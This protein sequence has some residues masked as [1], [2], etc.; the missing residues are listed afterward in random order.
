ML[1][2]VVCGGALS[3]CSVADI[4]DG[5]AS[6]ASNGGA[7]AAANTSSCST[8]T[9][10]LE[11]RDPSALPK[12]ACASGGTARCVSKDGIPASLASQ[13]ATC[14]AAA[15]G[16]CVPDAIVAGNA[17]TTCTSS[18][19]EGRCMSLCLPPVAANAS[20]LDRGQEN[21]CAE[22]E[23]CAPCTSPIDGKPTGVCD[24]A[25]PAAS[26]AT[27]GAPTAGGA[28]GQAGGAPPG[29]C[30]YVGPPLV[31]VTRFPACGAGMRCV[32]ANLVPPAAAA[33]LGK[34]DA[35]LCAPEKFIAAGG[36]YLPKSCASLAKAEGRCMNVAIPAV[37]SEQ[38]IL[39]TDAC[40][41]DERCVP[42]FDP[43]D[44]KATGVCS[45]VSCDAP[46]QPATTFAGCCKG[47]GGAARGKCVPS[48]MVPAA[49]QA[50]FD[51][52]TCAPQ[53]LCAPSEN[54]DPSYKPPACT[55]SSFVIGAYAG[56]C[57]SDCLDFGVYDLALETGSCGSGM[58]CVPCTANGSPTGAP[59]C[60]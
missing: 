50:V 37:A 44:G 47:G 27:N 29:A 22:D 7:A 10:T 56:V 35:G 3:A 14:D 12:C 36:Q 54:L 38:S 53:E 32:P 30:P 15:G 51:Q 57:L 45:I 42:C 43:A 2:V 11:K 33:I 1:M 19:G 17:P 48:A 8:S 28:G 39:P 6:G 31:D 58:E 9:S 59:G 40:D 18:Y 25:A 26:C 52:D 34:C 5:A 13:L 21:A 23:R 55:A 46:K 16:V 60:H 41:A 24:V 4:P 20:L 49:S